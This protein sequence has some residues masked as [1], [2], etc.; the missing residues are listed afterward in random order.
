MP[1]RKYPCKCGCGGVYT[2]RVCREHMR[3]SI[4]KMPAQQ[5]VQRR[6]SGQKLRKAREMIRR[7]SI[8]AAITRQ[9]SRNSNMDR[10]PSPTPSSYSK[11]FNFDDFDLEEDLPPTDPD[12]WQ[13]ILHHRHFN[14]RPD[15]KPDSHNT[16]STQPETD[17]PDELDDIS[18]ETLHD[19][20]GGFDLS[21]Y[22][23]SAE[24]IMDA[25]DI[26]EAVVEAHTLLEV[27]DI[28]NLSSFDLYVRYKPTEELFAELIRR[29]QPID[30]AQGARIPSIKRLRSLACTLSGFTPKRHHCCVNSCV[31][32]IGYLGDMTTCPVC[33]EGRLDSSGKPRNIF[34]TI[35]LI[36]QLRALFACPITVEKMRHRHTY[37]N[38]KGTMA[39][40][41]DSL[42]YLELCDLFVT[43]DGKPMPY[44]YFQ[45]EHEVA[46]GITLDGACP[47]KRRTNTCWPIL[48]INYN[49]PPEERICVENMICVGVIPGPQC[50]NDI[51]SFLQPL[52]DELRE[53][54]RGVAAVD[55]NQRKLFSL[56]AHPLTIFGDIPALT[57]VLEFIGHNGCFP[58]RFCLM[59]T[60]PG[61]TSGG[62]FHRYC[63]LHQPNGFRMDPLNLPLREHDDTIKT[64]LKVLKAKNE[65]ERKQ[66]AT[67]SGVK[68]VT[69]FA[70]VPS[71]S[72]PRSFPVDL[73]HMIWQNLLPQLIDLWTGDFNDLDG[74]LEDYELKKDVWGAL[75]EAC[76][77]SR[78]TM[79]TSFG[80]AVPD[81]RK[82]S[83][84]IAET[85]NVFTT[86]LAPSLLR[87]RFSDQRY[88]RHFVRL[89]KLLSLVVSFDL[90]RDKTPEIRQGFAEWVEEYEQIYYQF[91]EDR[92]QTC[93]VNVHYL[94]HI[95]DSIEYM[96]PIWCYW[97]YPME[98]FCSFIINS[99]K[100]RRYPYAN[101][102]ERVLNRARLQII[103]RKHRLID[104]EP[105]TRR[106]QPEESDG[107]TLVRGY[108]LVFLLS[109]HSKHLH[110]DRQLRRQIIRYLTT[111]FEILS[112]AA[113]ALIPEELEQWG[114]LRI[115]NGGDE[116][117]ARGFHKLRP[118]G[119]DAAFVRV[120]KY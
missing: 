45:E 78:Q 8:Q 39:D 109:P 101:I 86:Q 105:F 54:A 58:C 103:L 2:A 30:S 110:V 118:D 96:G 33:H 34:T 46:L 32:F 25:E 84:F 12:V 50:P 100:S 104:K 92:L 23:L 70:R 60:V 73:M 10:F 37:S 81:P 117:H 59:P 15:S 17:R 113:E 76:I 13:E 22:G 4:I 7:T 24:D 91:D 61:P 66:L 77:P 1:E 87:K 55:V 56:R 9:N 74:G 3:R 64:G 43:I 93:P 36:P 85:W 82:R 80:C 26:V 53:L 94:L 19:H 16:P 119:R 69:L 11:H 38:N 97:A 75:C 83:Y 67:E 35:P 115:G 116:V 40:I 112:S 90:P 71:I 31:A 14:E 21:T 27:E 68:G 95:A 42:R 18:I 47:F 102:D 65:A 98:R 52:I 5:P 28:H 41:F 88:Y 20:L 114:R 63:P 44:R 89:V 108:P 6:N 29:Y 48:I 106:R 57:K 120:S 72:I 51:N 79:P 99:V 107:A 111:C 62:G 49:L